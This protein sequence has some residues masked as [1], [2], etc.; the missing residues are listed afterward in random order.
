MERDSLVSRFTSHFSLKQ[1]NA[2]T[3]A[4]LLITLGIIGIVAALTIPNLMANHRKQVIETRLQKFYSVFNQ[5]ILLA[6]NKYGE[7]E[8]WDNADLFTP[9]GSGDWFNKYLAEFFTSKDV[10]VLSSSYYTSWIKLSDGS[11]FGMRF[12]NMTEET[13][14]DMYFFPNASD[15]EKCMVNTSATV[16]RDCCGRKYFTF[17]FTPQNRLRPYGSSITTLSR[18]T[19]IDYCSGKSGSGTSGRNYCTALIMRDGWKILKDYPRRI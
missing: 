9:S 7:I 1:K 6:E 16:D 2:F 14:F 15:I 12:G 19:L 3:L 5:A 10:E 13:N 8:Y 17:H 11:A 18:D 4:E